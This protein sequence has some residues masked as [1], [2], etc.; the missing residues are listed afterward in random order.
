[1]NRAL[2]LVSMKLGMKLPCNLKTKNLI[3]HMKKWAYFFYI[4][5]MERGKNNPKIQSAVSQ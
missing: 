2:F 5:P 4:M 1:M 3:V